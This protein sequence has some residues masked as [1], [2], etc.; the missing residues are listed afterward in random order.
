MLAH[1]VRLVPTPSQE[2]CF[3]R[4]CG[5]ARFA[6]NWALT[7]W[8]SQVSAGSKPTEAKLRKKLNSIKREQFPWM[9]DVTKNVPQQAIKNL[10]R[11]FSNFFD[12][13]EKQK[14][15]RI[16]LT[17]IRKPVLKKKGRRDSFRADNGCDSAN[18]NAV[19]VDSKR[20]RIPSVG[21]VK[22]REEFRFAGRIISVV[23]SRSA[24]QWYASFTTE[25][26]DED[27]YGGD[28][29]I[30]G[31]DLG[32]NAFATL[33]DDVV[34]KILAPKPL[35]KYLPLIKRYS[36]AL[37]RKQYGSRNR[38]KAKT[39]LAR[40]HLRVANIRTDALHKLTT[41]L[42]CYRRIV[43]EDL[44]VKGML[45]NRHLARSIADL[46][47]FE[48]RRQLEYKAKIA[49]NAVV[50]ANRW[51]PSSKRCSS[52]GRVNK[53]LR[54]TQR[55][56]TCESCG[57]THDRDRN[58]AYNLARYPESSPGAACGADDS[59]ARDPRRDD[60]GIEAG[61][62]CKFDFSLRTEEP[63]TEQRGERDGR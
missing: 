11:A 21:W 24:D 36:R 42:M 35:R 20:V 54:L 10:G 52:C 26:P 30:V 38:S 13:L 60:H 28:A 15:G 46:G 48:F 53:L 25:I 1:R 31:I 58:A 47:F 23:V 4:A 56:W 3:R 40:L 39:K 18:S 22:M 55:A 59:A 62:C 45:S 27:D 17:R 32:V 50:I 63:N 49:G 57:A 61:R 29:S 9:Y 8:Q 41:Y 34:Q 44:F 43:I 33:S 19:R 7:E 14:S 5:V 2:V 16:P 37:S 6:Y 51:F 12:D